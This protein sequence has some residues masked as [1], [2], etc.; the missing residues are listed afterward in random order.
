MSK[1]DGDPGALENIPD[2][3]GIVIVPSKKQATTEGEVHTRGAKYDALLGVDGDLSICPQVI[4][5]TLRYKGTKVELLLA[6]TCQSTDHTP[7][8]TTGDQQHL[9]PRPAV[10]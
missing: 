9:V 3:D 1:Q 5:A 7:T 2:I 6:S 4:E 10:V 8:I